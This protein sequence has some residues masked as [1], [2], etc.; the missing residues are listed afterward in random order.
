MTCPLQCGH[1]GSSMEHL[2]VIL[3]VNYIF[4]FCYLVS[5]AP[6]LIMVDLGNGGRERSIKVGKGH[7]PCQVGLGGSQWSVFWDFISVTLGLCR[8][9]HLRANIR[10]GMTWHGG[11]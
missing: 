9:G 7:D 1:L 11:S 2:A 8:G 6:A 4:G 5:F 3:T 10:F